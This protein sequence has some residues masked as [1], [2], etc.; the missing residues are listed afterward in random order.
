MRIFFKG[1]TLGFLI[2]LAWSTGDVL[3]SSRMYLGES[4]IHTIQ[5]GE[6]LS[7]LAQQ[8]YGDAAYWRELALIN[9]APNADNI[10]PGEQILLPTV[11]V[12]DKLARS[13]RLSE[14]NK[15]VGEQEQLATQESQ[16]QAKEFT[17]KQRIATSEQTAPAQT[18]PEPL[19]ENDSHLS[20]EPVLD[21]APLENTE[22]LDSEILPSTDL[23]SQSSLDAATLQHSAEPQEAGIGWLGIM[24]FGVGIV[25][26]AYGLVSYRRK[27]MNKAFKPLNVTSV[28]ILDEF[29]K[30]PS[31]ESPKKED[32][33]AAPKSIAA[34]KNNKAPVAI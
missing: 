14:V 10:F 31:I 19:P 20:E 33:K 18:K 6:Q 13:T 25:G 34:H 26:V 1:L 12:I 5:N 28:N 24:L 27:K 21:S 17:A 7:H 30:L 4:R 29:E 16:Q 2:T 23:S 32:K 11:N 9:R 15:L 8:Y 3:L 22:E